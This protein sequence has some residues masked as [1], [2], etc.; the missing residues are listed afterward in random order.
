MVGL[1]RKALREDACGE[2]RD[3]EERYNAKN[4]QYQQ[5]SRLKGNNNLGM[6]LTLEGGHKRGFA[7]FLFFVFTPQFRKENYP[8]ETGR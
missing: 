6:L 2:A 8:L 4:S 7:P 5:L 1:T 3:N